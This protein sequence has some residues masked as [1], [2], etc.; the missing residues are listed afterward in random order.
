MKR[1]RLGRF[2]K[3]HHY[4]VVTQF[5][6]NEHLGKDH[7]NWKGGRSKT[8]SGYILVNAI[9]HPRAYGNNVYEH[10]LVAEKKLGRCITKEE[11]V[12]HINGIKD[13]NRPENLIVLT[14]EK[15]HV[16]IHY[17][18]HQRKR[19]DNGRWLKLQFGY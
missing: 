19:G 12:H 4:N 16:K 18:E 17:K 8:P 5:K 15:E 11:R 13:D 2:I 14:N 6:K 9:G 10:I 7:P 3:G 1:D